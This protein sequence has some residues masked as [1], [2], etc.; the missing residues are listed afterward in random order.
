[1]ARFGVLDRITTDQ[2]RQFESEL[3][4]KLTRWTGTK[5]W[6]TTAYYLAANGMI[7][8]FHLQL[9]TAIKCHET[10]NWVDIFQ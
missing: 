10:E 4:R 1:M 9:K 5:H 8:R 2:G 6:R 7:E 3:F